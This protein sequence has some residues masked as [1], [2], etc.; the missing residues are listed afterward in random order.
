[1]DTLRLLGANLMDAE[2]DSFGSAAI[3]RHLLTYIAFGRYGRRPE[4]SRDPLFWSQS[5]ARHEQH[6]Q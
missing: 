4:S 2:D 5:A 6:D 1:V 3:A